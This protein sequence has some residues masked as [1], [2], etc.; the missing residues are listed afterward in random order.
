MNSITT[1]MYKSYTLR[2]Y[3]RAK[4]MKI[5]RAQDFDALKTYEGKAS[6]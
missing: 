5:L 3:V 4:L 6:R 1:N 2:K